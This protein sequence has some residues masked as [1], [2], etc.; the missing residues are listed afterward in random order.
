MKH[1]IAI[2]IFALSTTVAM[3]NPGG[4]IDGKR[5]TYEQLIER[6][7]VI[8]QDLSGRFWN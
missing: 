3:A 1:L 4:V 7:C 6:G 2:S 8:D 5:Y